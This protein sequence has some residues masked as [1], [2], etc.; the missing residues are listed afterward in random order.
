MLEKGA[1]LHNSADAE[2]EN[3]LSKKQGSVPSANVKF[4]TSFT[5]IEETEDS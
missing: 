4:V 3:G 2:V 5:N 1:S